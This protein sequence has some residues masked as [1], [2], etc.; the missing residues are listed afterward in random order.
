M[1]V[2]RMHLA[3]RVEIGAVKF[4][5]HVLVDLRVRFF[6]AVLF[7]ADEHC[8]FHARVDYVWH[9]VLS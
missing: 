3:V 7:G 2:H 4:L 9:C 6:A 5:D 8:T 1:Y